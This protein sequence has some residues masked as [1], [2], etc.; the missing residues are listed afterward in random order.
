LITGKPV[1]QLV[2]NTGQSIPT[3]VN[4]AVSF[5]G[6]GDEAID[7]DGQHS[8]TVNPTRV[9]IGNTLGLYRVTGSVAFPAS[10]TGTY[11]RCNIAFNGNQLTAGYGAGIQPNATFYSVNCG[12]FIVRATAATD[13]VELYALHD[14]T[15]ALTLA[16]TATYPDTSISTLLTVRKTST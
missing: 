10:A 6:A 5:P 8:T 9:T 16:A 13:Y 4:T 2:Q 11:R 14:A 7:S 3:G 12:P 1:C 15:S